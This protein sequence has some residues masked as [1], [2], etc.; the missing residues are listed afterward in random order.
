VPAG[1]RSAILA[2]ELASGGKADGERSATV[3]PESSR[4]D[5]PRILSLDLPLPEARV[6]LITE[7]EERYLEHVLAHGGNV[8]RAAAAAGVAR[9]HLQRLRA[10]RER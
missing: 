5:A 2:D 9:R 6:Q 7:F 4:G 3:A 8:T 10:K 1:S